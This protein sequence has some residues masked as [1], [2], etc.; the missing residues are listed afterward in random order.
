VY[1]PDLP[2]FSPQVLLETVLTAAD[3]ACIAIGAT[4]PG[5]SNLVLGFYEREPT[6]WQHRSWIDNSGYL[7][8]RRHVDKVVNLSAYCA[9]NLRIL[10]APKI[11]PG[12]T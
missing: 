11:P 8:P 6:G 2:T 12:A 5:Y 10:D 7:E 9:A 4:T 1:F 3:P